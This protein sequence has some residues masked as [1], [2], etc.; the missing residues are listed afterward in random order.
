MQEVKNEIIDSGVDNN[1]DGHC[2]LCGEFVDD[3]GKHKPRIK[4]ANKIYVDSF[5]SDTDQFNIELFIKDYYSKDI[6]YFD[7]EIN[8]NYKERYKLIKNYT[9]ND[10]ND[11][12]GCKAI[13]QFLRN[14]ILEDKR[15]IT[16][17]IEII[18]EMD[19]TISRFIVKKP[20]C[21]N[22]G[23]TFNNLDN[24]F[25]KTL[26][27]AYIRLNILKE[28]Y[29]LFRDNGYVSTSRSKEYAKTFAVPK[30][31]DKAVCLFR[32]LIPTGSK[33]M[34]LSTMYDT[35]MSDIEK[36]VLL[37]SGNDY[38]IIE[39][40]KKTINGIIYYEGIIELVRR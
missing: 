15:N 29:Y 38:K 19:E 4:E 36:E 18:N 17:M 40:D 2:D 16:K 30:E 35:T 12:F 8:R 24:P 26:N 11:P 5:A 14:D 23:M 32:Y 28:D 21:T 7:Y 25:I 27:N 13:N 10:V 6:P 34:P 39:I 37:E 1:N 33:A 20:L 9:K 31:N 22:R 3:G